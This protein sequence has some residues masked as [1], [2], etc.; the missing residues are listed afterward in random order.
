MAL[1]ERRED[2]AAAIDD[3]FARLDDES[4]LPESGG[5]LVSLSRFEA[6]QD[7]LLAR[8]GELGVW[9]AS[10]ESPKSL[11]EALSASSA[12]G[13]E[14]LA[15]V[16]LDF[17]AFSDG[18]A[19]SS[20]RL[21]RERYGYKGEIR[22]IGEVLLEQIAFMVRSGFTTYEIEDPKALEEFKAVCDEVR[23]VY[24]PTGDGQATALQRRLGRS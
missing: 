18:R 7:A 20:A 9:L 8:E 15:L 14:R 21:L 24:Q 11:V 23:V 1:L 19:F 3:R 13:L 6:E 16:A 10:N 2:G 5:V 17:P 4:A 12:G 22:A